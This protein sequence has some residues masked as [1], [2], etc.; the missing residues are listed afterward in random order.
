[1]SC[2]C[3][4][5]G[6]SP[7]LTS[8]DPFHLN[9]DLNLPN[10]ELN[11][12]KGTWTSMRQDVCASVHVMWRYQKSKS[13]GGNWGKRQK[14]NFVINTSLPA[15]MLVFFS[16]GEWVGVTGMGVSVSGAGDRWSPDGWMGLSGARARSPLSLL[17]YPRGSMSKKKSS[18]LTFLLK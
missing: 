9:L 14:T 6:S 10:A 7:I 3:A 13:L 12:K 16:H 1:M 5:L 18:N 2:A 11:R 17:L 4:H 15:I 8:Q